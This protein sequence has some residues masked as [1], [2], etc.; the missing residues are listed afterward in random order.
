VTRTIAGLK[1]KV[2]AAAFDPEGKR[3]ALG[4]ASGEVSVRDPGSGRELAAAACSAEVTELLF[5]PQ[6]NRLAG[7]SLI[8]RDT[9]SSH[10]K[11][12]T[13]W[14]LADGRAVHSEQVYCPF[15]VTRRDR[16]AP[17]KPWSLA[18]SGDGETLAGWLGDRYSRQP[19][20]VLLQFGAGDK[21]RRTRITSVYTSDPMLRSG[22][23]PMRLAF[24][25]AGKWLA[26][27][28]AP[29]LLGSSTEGQILGLW[30]L[31]ARREVIGPIRRKLSTSPA[32]GYLS[33]CCFALSPDFSRTAALQD[34]TCVTVSPLG[35]GSGPCLDTGAYAPMMAAS[36][37]GKLVS[38]GRRV[39]EVA[40]GRTSCE[41]EGTLPKSGSPFA[42]DEAE[43]KALFFSPRGK[44]L[45]LLSDELKV[46][47]A[48]TGRL[49]ASRKVSGPAAADPS[50]TLL[51]VGTP[52]ALLLA[53]T[54]TG[55]DRLR[56]GAAGKQVP[57]PL[58]VS[59]GGG[60]LA[61]LPAA[62]DDAVDLYDCRSGKL[63]R[64]LEGHAGGPSC[65]AFS[66]DGRLLAVGCMDG[67]IH[68]WET[69]AG[70]LLGVMTGHTAQVW[71]LS[72][73]AGGR[74]LVSLDRLPEP[75]P[76][77]DSPDPR[78]AGKG[79]VR[80]W[81]VETREAIFTAGTHARIARSFALSPDGRRL[82]TGGWDNTLRIWGADGGQELLALGPLNG[83]AT[84]T[85]FSSCGRYLIARVVR[86]GL[87]V[88]KAED[89]NAE[90]T[91]GRD[92]GATGEEAAGTADAPRDRRD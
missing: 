54:S 22:A 83:V 68:L 47:D 67:R 23:I 62:A 49:T 2:T 85:A 74:R 79:T 3:L 75:P 82:I 25:A 71:T 84:D 53:D 27:Y 64:R 9:R 88:W 45:V 26:L 57:T 58:A 14:R 76:N 59:S 19:C 66:A 70:R 43:V 38:D 16:P 6:G 72:F 90:P 11:T 30:D 20:L 32:A 63:L 29:S 78:S 8:S 89:W 80:L 24:G 87:V 51:A 60:A 1:G 77:E 55:E 7:L 33:R 15:G 92:A 44:K 36:P 42:T 86:H 46:F 50:G 17:G 91:P 10:R 39:Y 31:S 21:P 48:R 69:E 5:S 41:L 56:I 37:D 4:C 52:G 12:L 61:V 35:A 65:A 40:T 73:G 28:G 18:F 81:N 13:V 34:Q